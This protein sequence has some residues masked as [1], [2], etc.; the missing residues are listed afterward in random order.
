MDAICEGI[1]QVLMPY[2][3]ALVDLEKSIL[4]TENVQLS[5]FQHKLAPYEAVLRAMLNLIYQVIILS[6]FFCFRDDGI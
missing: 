5:Y 2:R 3:R 1:D 4:K 6:C